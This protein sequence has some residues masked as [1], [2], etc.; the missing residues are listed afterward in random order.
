MK[1]IYDVSVPINQNMVIWPGDPS[2]KIERVIKIEEG[3]SSNITYL[4]IG[5][6]TGTHIDAP[7]HFIENGAKIDDIPLDT[8]IGPVQ[9]IEVPDKYSAV[10]AEF[11]MESD[12]SNQYQ[13]ILFKTN[14]SKS[15]DVNSD[16]NKNFVA[17]DYSAAEY[18]VNIGCKLVGIDYLSIAPYDDIVRVHQL[19]LGAG[20][21]L[22][23]GLNLEQVSAGI[24]QLYCL[25]L[26]L[27]GVE[28]A[29]TRVI[30]I[31]E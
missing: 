28:A 13:R 26:K 27:T 21:V 11:L 16:F 30:L 8:L 18:L 12:L 25:P 19:L 6:H 7:Y 2:V 5:L 14:N 24:Y 17:I 9:V 29:L 10:N 20:I 23:E 15:L 22:L 4:N 1:K 3:E 31:Q